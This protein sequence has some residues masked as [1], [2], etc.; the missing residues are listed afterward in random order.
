MIYSLSSQYNDVMVCN[1][2][3]QDIPVKSPDIRSYNLMRSSLIILD[4]VELMLVTIIV[5][6]FSIRTWVSIVFIVERFT[7]SNCSYELKLYLPCCLD[8]MVL[9]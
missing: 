5:I 2:R 3:S 7:L 4:V 8:S 1:I 9:T 6:N